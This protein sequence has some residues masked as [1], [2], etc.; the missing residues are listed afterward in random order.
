VAGVVEAGLARVL[1]LPEPPVTTVAGRTDAG[2]HAQGQVAHVDVP[3]AAWQA[4]P[5]PVRRLGGVLP[6]DVRVTAVTVAPH[7]FDARFSAV[8]RRYRYRVADGPSGPDP[9]LRGFVVAH[10]RRVDVAGM[11]VAAAGLLGEHDFAAFCRRREGASTVRTLLDLTWHR[12]ESGLAVMDVRADAFCHSMVRA[13]VGVLLPVGDGRRPV[14]WPE[15]VLAA[16]RRDSAVTVAPA[17]GL[18]LV[19]VGYPPDGELGQRQQV[20]RRF[21]GPSA[22]VATTG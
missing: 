12:T 13:L 14:A 17:R 19:E 9:L 20:T 11:N 18:V 10:R 2:V 4:T 21:R 16:G 1:R 3:A 6:P 7:G 5:D 15:Q 8:W 22:A